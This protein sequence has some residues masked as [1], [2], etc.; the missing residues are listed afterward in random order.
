[1]AI[2]V[3]LF[4]GSELPPGCFTRIMDD[5]P[6]EDPLS[7]LQIP[8][9]TTT[10]MASAGALIVCVPILLF[11]I[12]G[13]QSNA[14]VRLP[15]ERGTDKSKLLRGWIGWF[16]LFAGLLLLNFIDTSIDTPVARIFLNE[17]TLQR[18]SLFFLAL[19]A[20]IYWRWA[21]EA[22]LPWFLLS[23]FLAPSSR[24][25][26]Y[27]ILCS[28]SLSVFISSILSLVVLKSFHFTR[29]LQV[30]LYGYSAAILISLLIEVPRYF[31]P[32]QHN[33]LFGLLSGLL[34]LPQIAPAAVQSYAFFRGE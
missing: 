34:T 26:P 14:E 3:D 1:M 19:I 6:V 23:I 5:L 17:T 27:P 2:V 9:L 22:L 18:V 11:A 13:G 7:M 10:A 8:T 24:L 25:V 21:A 32:L 33:L 30:A 15:L 29:T 12:E 20:V 4:T 28:F 31:L 16:I